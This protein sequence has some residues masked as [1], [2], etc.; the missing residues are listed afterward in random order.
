LASIP[1]VAKLRLDCCLK[2]VPGTW[3]KEVRRK[4]GRR[5]ERP[6]KCRGATDAKGIFGRKERIKPSELSEFGFA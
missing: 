6:T 3:S 4:A 1:L 2:R 5:A